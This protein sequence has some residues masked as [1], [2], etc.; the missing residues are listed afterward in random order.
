MKKIVFSL[1]L[2]ATLLVP[3]FVQ[4]EA[5]EVS[6]D[7]WIEEKLSDYEPLIEI[8]K[9]NSDLKLVQSNTEYILTTVVKDSAGNVLHSK[10]NQFSDLES[11]NSYKSVQQSMKVVVTPSTVSPGDTTYEE[12]DTIKVGLSLYKY[13]TNRFFVACV[14]DFTGGFFV[15]PINYRGIA[16]LALDSN[17][18]MEGSSSYAGRISLYRN[19]TLMKEFS[20]NAGNLSIK[21]SSSN[22]IGYSYSYTLTGNNP[23]DHYEGVISCTALKNS[24]NTYCS[25]FGEYDWL[26]SSLSGF[27]VSYPL[28]ISVS[29]STERDRYTIQEPLDIR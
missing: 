9:E 2:I 17:M 25:A 19:G 11:L 1:L 13:S 3:N 16:G 24:T 28:G 23:L 20:T 12:Y 6:N 21:A 5:K 15:N 8:K 7:A 22:A 4:V 26:Y 10:K 27:S 14:Y 29:G 18:A